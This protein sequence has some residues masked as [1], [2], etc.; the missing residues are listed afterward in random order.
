MRVHI[1]RLLGV[2]VVLA[3]VIVGVVVVVGESGICSLDPEPAAWNLQP[4]FWNLESG[5]WS[6]EP[7]VWSLGPGIWI[8][9][10]GA[11]YANYPSVTPTRE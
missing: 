10:S 3:P 8:L 6:L 4:V 1:L 5:A 2:A 9:E 11:K 7:G